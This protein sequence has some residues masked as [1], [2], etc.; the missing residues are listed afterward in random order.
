MNNYNKIFIVR[1]MVS[2]TLALQGNHKKKINLSFDDTLSVG[3]FSFVK[4]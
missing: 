1:K 3:T 2:V 4:L